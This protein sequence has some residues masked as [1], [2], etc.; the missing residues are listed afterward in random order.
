MKQTPVKSKKNSADTVPFALKGVSTTRFSIQQ[1]EGEK[2]TKAKLG[3]QV[4]FLSSP[5]TRMVGA[6]FRVILKREEQE[7]VFLEIAC[8]FEFTE[9]AWNNLPEEDGEKVLPVPLALHLATISAGTARGVFHA[10]T[11]NTPYSRYFLS[12]VNLTKII[13]A[14]VKL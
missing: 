13:T 12:A 1:A 9:T 14:P 2:G 5:E 3:F 6:A 8:H 4:G 10:K 11:E 7:L